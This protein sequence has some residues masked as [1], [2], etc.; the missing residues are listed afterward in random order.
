MEIDSVDPV[1]P[2]GEAA[3]DGCTCFRLRCLARLTGR[4]FDARMAAVGLKTTQYSLLSAL[5]RRGPSRASDLARALSLDASTLTRNVEPLIKAGWVEVAVGDDRRTRLLRLTASG[6]AQRQR[7]RKAWV[8]AQRNIEQVLGP[9][10]VATLH[11]LLDHCRDVLEAAEQADDGHGAEPSGTGPTGPDD[12]DGFSSPGSPRKAAQPSRLK[13]RSKPGIADQN[14]K[15]GKSSEPGA[16]KPGRSKPGK[17]QQ[18]GKPARPAEAVKGAP[19][20]ARP[21]RSS[22]NGTRT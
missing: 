16:S 22:R 3:L 20:A 14:S 4:R 7:A 6:T 21:S 19:R 1:D 8:G 18:R 17:P 11:R 5:W 9:D 13:V 10:T 15:P 2:A 12:P